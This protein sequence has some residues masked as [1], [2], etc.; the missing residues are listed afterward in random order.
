VEGIYLAG[1]GLSMPHERTAIIR[2][3]SITSDEIDEVKRRLNRIIDKARQAKA[4]G[5]VT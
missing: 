4:E 2:L 3:A 5:E 1:S